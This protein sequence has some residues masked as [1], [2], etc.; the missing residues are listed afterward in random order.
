MEIYCFHSKK[1]Q[2][3]KLIYGML[4]MLVLIVAIA[5]ILAIKA[6][7]SIDPPHLSCQQSCLVS[8]PAL[9]AHLPSQPT[10]LVSPPA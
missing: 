10:C 1:S 8:P 3:A 5:Q 2:Y 9:S 7:A 6:G 4:S